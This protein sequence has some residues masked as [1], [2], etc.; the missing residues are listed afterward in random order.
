MTQEL[1][2]SETAEMRDP[3][4]DSAMMIQTLMLDWIIAKPGDEAK[5]VWNRIEEKLAALATSADQSAN[6]AALAATSAE[7]T[8]DADAKSETLNRVYDLVGMGALARTPGILM[9][10]LEN[11]QRRSHCLSGIESLF[12]YEVPDEHDEW[13]TADECDL[14]WGQ[15]RDQYV[16]TFKAALPAFIARHPEYAAPLPRSASTGTS[17]TPALE[18][19]PDGRKLFRCD[20]SKVARSAA[21]VPSKETVTRL[22][23]KHGGPVHDEGWCLNESGL[24]DFLRELFAAVAEPAATV[25]D[26][27][28]AFEAAIDDART[29]FKDSHRDARDAIEYVLS[30][31]QARATS[32][33]ATVTLTHKQRSAIKYAILAIKSVPG[34]A[35][36]QVDELEGLLATVEQSAAPQAEPIYQAMATDDDPNNGDVW[37]DVDLRAFAWMEKRPDVRCRIVYADPLP[38]ASEQGADEALTDSEIDDLWIRRPTIHNGELM[39]QLRDFARAILVRARE[40]K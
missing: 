3:L 7:P 25:S 37:M 36:Y 19:V 18:P 15:E 40:P 39:P 29:V 35:G 9:T 20:M 33:Q 38:R 28:E 21:T 6:G 10:N 17:G 34:W 22:F 32:T 12:T 5:A 24:N 1:N 27:R 2:R 8:A 13:E 4:P 31:M 14:N 30:S 16:E 11:M 23:N 26:E